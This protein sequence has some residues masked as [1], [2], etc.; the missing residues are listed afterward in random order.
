[1]RKKPYKKHKNRLEPNDFDQIKLLLEK[2]FTNRQIKEII[3]WSGGVIYEIKRF[4]TFEEYEEYKETMRQR[5]AASKARHMGLRSEAEIL[6]SK[7]AETL[8]YQTE[9]LSL[10]KRI[11]NALEQRS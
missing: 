5:I 9:V 7:P 4:K 10:L 11:A 2:G 8:D 3:G 6:P 1:M